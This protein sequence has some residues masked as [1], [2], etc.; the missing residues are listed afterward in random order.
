MA[1][2]AFTV[3][4]VLLAIAFTCGVWLAWR[5]AGNSHARSAAAAAIAAAGTAIWMAITWRVAA[6]GAL[7]RWNDMPP[8]FALLVIAI[9][10]LAFR[11]AFSTTGRRL[12]EH[13]PLWAL[14]GVQA[15]RYPLELAMHGMYERGVMPIQMSYSGLNF[16]IVTG[17]TAILVAGLLATGRIGRRTVM[18]WNVMGL[19]LLANIVVVAILSTPRFRY[20]GEDRLNVWVTYPPYVWLPAVMVVAALA[21]HLLVFRALRLQARQRGTVSAPSGTAHLPR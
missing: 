19:L 13:V 7:R 20:F 11:L 18:A 8:P 16:D 9:F 2:L 6:G 4:P 14:V 17:I 1:E 10:L 21:G 12:A 15:F 3:L 5:R